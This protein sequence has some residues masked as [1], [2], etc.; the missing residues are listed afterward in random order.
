MK[1]KMNSK[2]ENKARKRWVKRVEKEKDEVKW[3][4]VIKYK[5]KGKKNER[6]LQSKKKQQ[7]K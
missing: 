5:G 3:E 2:S 4:E 7:T 1:R 6:Q